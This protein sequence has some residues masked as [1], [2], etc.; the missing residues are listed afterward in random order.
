[1]SE[2]FSIT[3][4]SND[5]VP[6]DVK[7]YTIGQ[8]QNAST[9]F[10]C[11]VCGTALTYGGRGRHPKFCD[12]HKPKKSASSR[13]SGGIPV[14]V[15]IDQ[16]QTLYVAMATGATF[17]PYALDGMVIAEN[18]TTLAE[19][20]RPLILRDPKI[21]KFWEKICTGG[22]WGTVIFAHGLVAMQIAKMHGVAIPGITPTEPAPSV[23]P[24]G[25]QSS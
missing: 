16:I 12:E 5:E 22:G 4:A 9:G 1:M 17:T 21:R 14:D 20:W 19:S 13:T 6:P 7:A 23:R 3:I 18:A 10:Q 25:D 8:E 24:E 15:L 11:I 2:P